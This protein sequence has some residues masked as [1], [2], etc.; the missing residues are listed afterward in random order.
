MFGHPK[1]S[2]LNNFVYC[3]CPNAPNGPWSLK[4]IGIGSGH[5]SSREFGYGPY[6]GGSMNVWVHNGKYLRFSEQN[7]VELDF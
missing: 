4:I 3:N 7:V 2:F 1:R 6:L 5:D